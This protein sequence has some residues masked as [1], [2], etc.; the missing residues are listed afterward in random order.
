MAEE[1]M[2]WG[3]YF[4]AYLIGTIILAYLIKWICVNPLIKEIQITRKI[5]AAASMKNQTLSN[6]EIESI[7][8]VGKSS[9]KW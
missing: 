3:I 2:A 8:L 1:I 6:V 7:E 5:I 4:I 9:L